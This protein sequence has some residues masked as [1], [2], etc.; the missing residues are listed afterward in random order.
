[1]RNPLKQKNKTSN[2][3][4][5]KTAC[6]VI[7]TYNEINNIVS[8][9]DQI[10]LNEKKNISK[11][12]VALK[13]LVVD[14]NSPDG[15]ADA[16]RKYQKNNSKVHLL[17]RQNKEGL[18]AA[19]I[20]GMQYALKNLNSD[21]LFEMDADHS[22]DPKDIYK[23]IEAIK[24]GA[25]FVIGS[26]YIAG[27]GIEEGWGFH[28]YLISTLARSITR[29][30]LKLGNIKDCSGGFRAIRSSALK[31]LDLKNLHVKGYAFQ[32]ALLESA[33]HN[34]CKITEVPIFFNRRTEGKS[35]MKT[36]DMLEGF[37]IIYQIRK[38]RMLNNLMERKI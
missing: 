25:D 28:R 35:K 11:S 3:S 5:I 6:I 34:D 19:Y 37:K 10:F 16:V 22:H 24:Q 2:S 32:A 26:R 18:G 14:D 31:K 29:K 27:G 9:M 8:L 4:P 1:M 13:I 23:M 36:S 30:G 21:I 7:P 15:T 12:K 17:V 38:K 20:A 33:V